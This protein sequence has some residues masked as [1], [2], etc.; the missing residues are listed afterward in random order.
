MRRS[1]RQITDTREIE[2]ILSISKVIRIAMIDNDGRP[3]VV[4]MNF[5]YSKG[6][7]F[8]HSAMHGKKAEIFKKSPEVCFELEY[9]SELI[10]GDTACSWSYEYESIIGMGNICV[11]ENVDEK[12]KGLD[13]LMRQYGS[14]DN[15]FPEKLV[16]KTLVLR[17]D[18][19]EIKAKR[20]RRIKNT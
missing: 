15:E 18:I 9:H 12:L 7:I 8:L 10:K 2:N 14:I 5:G 1:E 17:I 11:I 16:A 4:P 13:T 3:Y 6:K 20:N 19:T